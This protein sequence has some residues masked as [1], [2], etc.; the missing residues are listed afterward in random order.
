M[1]K[2][3]FAYVHPTGICISIKKAVHSLEGEWSTA[4]AG[5]CDF[6]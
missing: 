6:F 5:S 2:S 1:Q 4:K 3:V